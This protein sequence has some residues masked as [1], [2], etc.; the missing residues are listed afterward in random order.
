MPPQPVIKEEIPL[1]QKATRPLEVPKTINL[2]DLSALGLDLGNNLGQS[3]SQNSQTSQNDENTTSVV[4]GRL[5]EAVK[6]LALTSDF[7][8]FLA[9]IRAPLIVAP[10][11]TSEVSKGPTHVA[12]L[13]MH[14]AVQIKQIPL[15]ELLTIARNKVFDIFFYQIVNFKNIYSYL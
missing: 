9:G 14:W 3:T 7:D 2:E 4:D 8:M 5:V 12:S 11:L 13:V 6:G 10:S 15:L 1:Q